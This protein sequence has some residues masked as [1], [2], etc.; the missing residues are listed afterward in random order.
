[1]SV[2]LL[3]ALVGVALSCVNVGAAVVS[4][5]IAFRKNIAA[6]VTIVLGSM[7]VR[8]LVVLLVIVTLIT[9][10]NIR[11]FPFVLAFFISYGAL[12]LV[13]IVLVHRVY[14]KAAERR[15]RKL[16]RLAAQR[17]VRNMVVGKKVQN[18]A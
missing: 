7:I 6:F 18:Y 5:Y 14:R 4:A 12:V 10:T 16:Y 3:S 11:A 8:M 9:L 15:Q 17:S 2:D 1:M 13:E